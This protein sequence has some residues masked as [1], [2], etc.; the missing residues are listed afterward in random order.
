MNTAVVLALAG[1]GQVEQIAT[2]FGVDWLHLGAQVVSFGI[3]C[4]VLYKFAYKRI[5][6]MLETRRQQIAMGMA[7]AEKIKAELDAIEASRQEVLAK[8]YNEGA[9]YIEEARVTAARVQEQETQKAVA[10]AAEIVA[11]A[12][13]ATVQEHDRMLGELKREV[14]KLVVQTSTAVTGKIL[15]AEDQRRLAEETARELAGV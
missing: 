12:H 3:V 13:E 8:A 7:N 1:S 15:T 10:A 11:K 4:I 2:T 6:E 5:L 9:K 14:G